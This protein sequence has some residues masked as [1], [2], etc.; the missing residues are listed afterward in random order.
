MDIDEHASASCGDIISL[1]LHKHRASNLF[2]FCCL[3]WFHFSIFN[4]FL[5][6]FIAH[7]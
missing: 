1:P 2:V 6:P 4:V 3:F 5:C 7:T